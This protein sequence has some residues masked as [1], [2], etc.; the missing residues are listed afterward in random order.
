MQRCRRRRSVGSAYL[1]RSADPCRSSGGRWFGAFSRGIHKRNFGTLGHTAYYDL[2]L[3][4]VL[5]RYNARNKAAAASRVNHRLA[6]LLEN[7]LGWQAKCV[8]H[9][10]AE[11]DDLGGEAGTQT[12]VRLI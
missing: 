10:I 11:H 5:D 8:T 6:I 7:S 9:L 1:R 2:A 12:H 4:A 3:R